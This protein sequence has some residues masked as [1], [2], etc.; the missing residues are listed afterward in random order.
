MS[1]LNSYLKQAN[2]LGFIPVHFFFLF[3]YRRMRKRGV[4]YPSWC[5]CLISKH[6]TYRDH[7]SVQLEFTVAWY[8]WREALDVGGRGGVDCWLSRFGPWVEG[9]GSGSLCYVLGKTEDEISARGAWVNLWMTNIS[10]KWSELTLCSLMLLEVILKLW[11]WKV[12]ISSEAAM[13]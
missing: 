10:S 13:F 6:V 11:T 9:P 1:F 3:F 8:W 2:W 7:R 5:L 12:H 4:V